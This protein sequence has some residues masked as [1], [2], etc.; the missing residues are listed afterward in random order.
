MSTTGTLSI[1]I[2]Q[3]DKS[4]SSITIKLIGTPAPQ[5]SKKFVGRAK[6]GRGI[7]AEDCTRVKPWREAVTAAAI[8]A[9][10]GQPG[11]GISGPVVAEMIFTMPKPKSASKRRKTWPDRKPDLSKLVRSTEDALCAAG[12]FEDDARIIRCVSEKVFPGEHPDA[13]RVPGAVLR[14]TSALL[15]QTIQAETYDLEQLTKSLGTREIPQ[16]A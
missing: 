2:A 13:L 5:G 14:L 9:M 12:A 4:I 7:M 6:N 15:Q 8:D 1:L 10:D 16:H 11:R 3:Q